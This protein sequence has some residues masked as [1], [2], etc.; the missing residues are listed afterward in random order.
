MKGTRNRK[1]AS[2][3]ING[4]WNVLSFAEKEKKGKGK[5]GEKGGSLPERKCTVS[6]T[7]GGCRGAEPPCIS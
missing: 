7:E 4:H 3:K 6:S 1:K 5:R 2:R